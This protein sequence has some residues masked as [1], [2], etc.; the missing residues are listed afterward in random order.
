MTNP[1]FAQLAATPN[2]IPAA[3]QPEANVSQPEP[4]I[5]IQLPSGAIAAKKSLKGRDFFKF[6]SM[7]AKDATNALKWVVMKAFEVNGETLDINKLEDEM[8]FDDVAVL[9][10]EINKAFLPYLGQAS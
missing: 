5:V 4:N 6:Q 9:S 2:T 7:A 8:S 3:S 10:S 1:E